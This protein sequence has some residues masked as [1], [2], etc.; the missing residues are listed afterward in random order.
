M[1]K[2][3][4][5]KILDRYLSGRFSVEKERFGFAIR[6]S[7]YKRHGLQIRASSKIRASGSDYYGL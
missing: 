5:A 1:D 6:A 3:K 2:N 4:T 7:Q